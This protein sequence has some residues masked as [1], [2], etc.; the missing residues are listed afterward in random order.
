M[1]CAGGDAPS[2]RVRR[3]G[4]ASRRD[5]RGDA[6]VRRG[7]VAV[8]GKS[9]GEVKGRGKGKELRFERCL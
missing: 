2:S 9:R 1:A 5:R 6:E 8:G 3:L 7:K 4:S